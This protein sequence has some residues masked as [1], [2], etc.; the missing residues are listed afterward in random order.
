MNPGFW[1]PKLCKNTKNYSTSPKIVIKLLKIWVRGPGSG[2]RKKP[3]FGSRIQCQKGIGSRIQGKKR[4]GSS[5]QC[6]KGPGSRVKRHR[7][8]DPG[9]ATLEKR[10]FGGRPEDGG[11]AAAGSGGGHGAA[12]A[13]LPL[14]GR[15]HHRP[16]PHRGLPGPGGAVGH[17]APRHH[18]PHVRRCRRRRG[19]S[20]Y[21]SAGRFL[22]G[23]G[24]ALI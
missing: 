15:A 23:C 21:V 3:F 16:P 19:R 11:A 5:I 6:Q 22:Q 20:S 12:P 7:S 10:Q 8:P 18:P 9:S 17:L 4:T 2:I 13:S 14:P 1:L 24:F